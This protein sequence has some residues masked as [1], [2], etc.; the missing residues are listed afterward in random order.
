MKML[1]PIPDV[2]DNDPLVFSMLVAVL[3]LKARAY[4]QDLCIRQPF[5]FVRI[6]AD[7]VQRLT[8]AGGLTDCPHTPE[9]FIH[10]SN[11]GLADA[12]KANRFVDAHGLQILGG[13]AKAAAHMALD[14]H[15]SDPPLP[16]T[17]ASRT[18]RRVSNIDEASASS[19]A[20]CPR[21]TIPALSCLAI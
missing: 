17:K 5:I 12:N 19:I 3:F 13:G 4:A 15:A 10:V 2:F 1:S 8:G 11:A 14:N 6:D 20:P 18:S 16:L 21:R 7:V 9:C